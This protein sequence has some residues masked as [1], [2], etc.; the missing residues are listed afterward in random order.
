MP[1]VLEHV[2][3]VGCLLLLEADYIKTLHSSPIDYGLTVGALSSFGYQTTV[4]I[5]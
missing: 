4:F 5:P 2:E 1:N 3:N